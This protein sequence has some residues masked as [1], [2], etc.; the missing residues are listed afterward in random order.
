MSD[1][2]GKMPYNPPHVLGDKSNE[3]TFSPSRPQPQT[4][5][6]WGTPST[7]TIPTMPSSQGSKRNSTTSVAEAQ[8]D[9]GSCCVDY[10]TIKRDALDEDFDA[11]FH[12]NFLAVK[13]GVRLM[14]QRGEVK[15]RV[16][17]FIKQAG[18][19]IYVDWF[20]LL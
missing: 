1:E 16:R 6:Q 3:S 15:S 5:L 13:M 9:L 20:G 12:P 17:G 14:G 18:D 7:L 10:G 8:A 4:P 11:V 2:E 19:I